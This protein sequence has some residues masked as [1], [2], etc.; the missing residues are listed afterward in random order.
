MIKRFYSKELIGFDNVELDFG[1]GLTVFTGPSGAGK[2]VLMDGVLSAFGFREALAQSCELVTEFNLPILDEMGIDNEAENVFRFQKKDKTRYFVNSSQISKKELLGLAKNFAGYL[3]PKEGDELSGDGLIQFLDSFAPKT[4]FS[5]LAKYREHFLSLKELKAEYTELLEKALRA[6]DEKE[7]LE[8]EIKKFSQINPKEG[9]EEELALLKKE[10]A[11]KDKMEGVIS[12][13]SAGLQ[14]KSAVY[15]LIDFLGI[16]GSF[17]DRF[18]SEVEDALSVAGEKLSKLDETDIEYVFDRLEKIASVTKKYGGIKE[19]IEYFD[20]KKLELKELDG[21]EE[22][23]E[24]VALAIR[25]GEKTLFEIG[26]ELSNQRQ[27]VLPKATKELGFYLEK[28][29]LAKP[30]IEISSTETPKS[31]G[32]DEIMLKIG[33]ADAKKLSS[34]EYRRLRL[35]LMAAKIDSE[36]C[37]ALFLD[38]ADANLSGEESAGVAYV[39]RELSAKYQIFAISHQPQLAAVA[40]NHFLVTKNKTQSVVSKISGEER[41]SEIARMVSSGEITKEATEYAKKMLH[42]AGGDR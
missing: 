28:L 6:S 42:T 1:N 27:K 22:K 10:L 19:A 33:T 31:T 24:S 8:F 40:N 30:S 32:F 7:F 13:A 14:H 23:K 41:V 34:G 2:S 21:I 26:K 3:S 36:F 5:N 9:E 17:A 15:E 18:Y 39:L 12:K 29:I 38:E 20:A 16:D 4:H 37:G 11:K 35:A 25:E